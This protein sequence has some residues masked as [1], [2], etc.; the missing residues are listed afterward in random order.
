[1]VAMPLLDGVLRLRYVFLVAI[2]LL[3][4]VG[5]ARHLT[6]DNDWQFF[7]WGSD[8]L[9][10]AHYRFVRTTGS[11][12]GSAAGGL[13]LYGNYAFLQIGPPSLLLAKVLQVG[14]REGLYVAGAVTQALGLG[15]VYCIDR[16]FGRTGRRSALAILI[17]GTL[18]MVVWGSLTH[19]THL[20][21]ALTLAA[22]SAG[23]WALRCGRW[24]LAGALLGLSAASKPWGVVVLALV[25]VPTT[26]RAR[27]ITASAAAVIVLAFWGPF[28]V[29]DRRTLELGEVTLLVS[30]SSALAALGISHISDPSSLRL[31]QFGL[32]LAVATAV[33]LSR[34]WALAPLAG[35][36]LRL[37]IEP[38][39]YQYYATGV[40]T[41][42][43]LADVAV[44]RARVP[45]LT[46]L[47][48]A[49]WLAVEVST[50][51]EAASWLRFSTYGAL[52]IATALL[53]R[54]A[55]PSGPADPLASPAATSANS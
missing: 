55:S 31:L 47:A 51:A 30:P 19:F 22:L 13:H 35:F 7:T 9:F 20:D 29:A 16:A 39:A 28:V 33:V 18:L 48:T 40:V 43:L 10:G 44:V 1:M 45:V 5:G 6:G 32:G 12:D 2:A 53:M 38:S 41:A 36:S 27:A 17:G 50:T 42:A 46:C 3:M 25:L 24:P 21:D 4:Y 26:W 11:F 8:L 49:G 34:R 54:F 52:L 15:T 14:P 23:V 37:F